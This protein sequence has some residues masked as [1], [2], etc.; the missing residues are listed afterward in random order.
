MIHTVREGSVTKDFQHSSSR[1]GLMFRRL[2][3]SSVF[4][5]ASKWSKDQWEFKPD[6][7]KYFVGDWKSRSS[8]ALSDSGHFLF[9]VAI[10]YGEHIVVSLLVV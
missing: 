6:V 4:Q 5:R 8:A 3:N 7:E 10:M 2:R 1:V 9:E